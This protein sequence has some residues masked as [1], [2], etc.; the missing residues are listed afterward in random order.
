MSASASPVI[1]TKSAGSKPPGSVAILG[2]LC[3]LFAMLALCAGG[4]RFVRPENALG[5]DVISGVF[6][7]AAARN[8]F[9]LGVIAWMVLGVLLAVAGAGLLL[10]LRWARTVALVWAW[11]DIAVVILLM[12]YNLVVVVP[13]LDESELLF[14]QIFWTAASGPMT[15]CCPTMWALVLLAALYTD[16]I[17]LWA[18]GATPSSASGS[19]AGTSASRPVL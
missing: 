1:S 5:A 17:T 2:A 16:G 7:V 10:G 14:V 12:L 4:V 15:G 3:L 9:Y 13:A 18:R 8:A 6:D 11:S 19:G